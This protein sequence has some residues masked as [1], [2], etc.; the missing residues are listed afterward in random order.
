[1]RALFSRL[2]IAMLVATACAVRDVPLGVEADSEEG[3]SVNQE[4]KITWNDRIDASED[5]NH[6][7]CGDFVF[8]AWAE[9]FLAGCKLGSSE[10]CDSRIAWVWA[11]ARQCD[12]W[13]A[14]LLRNH[15]QHVRRDEIPEPDM[16]LE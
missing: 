6:H 16:R 12:E 13:Q 8:D 4:W 5:L 1:M 14:Y 9:N 7:P 2:A 15:F 10:E 3:S 11:R